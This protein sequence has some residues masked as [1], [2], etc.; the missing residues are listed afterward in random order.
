MKLKEHIKNIRI[1]TLK[2]TYS[3]QA[4]HIGSCFS[5]VEIL[6]SLYSSIF[7]HPSN[8]QKNRVLY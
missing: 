5:C 2:M 6:A 7:N 8:N 3:A 4:E 1:R